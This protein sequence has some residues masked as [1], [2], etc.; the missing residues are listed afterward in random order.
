MCGLQA[1]VAFPTSGPG[2]LVSA[3]RS[4]CEAAGV[5]IRTSCEVAG[6]VMEDNRVTGA[7]FASGEIV[8]TSLVLSSISRRRT[9]LH[10]ANG[11]GVGFAERRTI[12]AVSGVA[13]AKI[14][15][16]LDRLP[17]A[18][19]VT[20]ILKGRLILAERLESYAVAHADSRAGRIS[21]E[22]VMEVV[23]PTV[24]DPT[25]AT[26]GGHVVSI[27]V[28]PVP[29]DVAG[30]WEGSKAR[31]TAKVLAKL[32]HHLPGLVKHIVAA[33]ILTPDVLESRYGVEFGHTDISRMLG[34]WPARV[35][36]NIDGLLLCGADA[37]VVPSVSG[38][39]GRIAATL[40]MA[41]AR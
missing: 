23:F 11:A 31:F 28:Q 6:V 35:R 5:E 25:L 29:R 21:D 1:A 24:A 16:V 14:N 19:D 40:A 22:L 17:D 38:R 7:R 32:N 2:A 10:L 39:A 26:Q 27:L 34:G 9:L 12:D 20:G 30:G 4:A 8:G 13:S 37:D 3:L 15:L 41:S 33:D 36:T 18:S